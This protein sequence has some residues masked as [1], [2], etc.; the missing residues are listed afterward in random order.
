M[1]WYFKISLNPLR[2]TFDY[3][4][5]YTWVLHQYIFGYCVIIYFIKNGR[6][7]LGD[8]EV[9]GCLQYTYNISYGN[10]YTLYRLGEINLVDL[11]IILRVY[12]RTR[13]FKHFLLPTLHWF[14]LSY[15]ISTSVVS[16]KI[17]LTIF[18]FFFY[19]FT[20]YTYQSY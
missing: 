13:R 9:W 4:S 12:N 8:W 3:N 6:K 14:S 15:Q 19:I 1:F 16:T 17:L 5:M 18:T 11:K 2:Y 7:C 20:I 10:A